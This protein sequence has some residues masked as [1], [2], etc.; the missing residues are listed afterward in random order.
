MH[1]CQFLDLERGLETSCV[2]IA[3]PHH[4]QRLAGI[5]LGRQLAHRVVL[6]QHLQDTSLHDNTS[7]EPSFL[8]GMEKS[9]NKLYEIRK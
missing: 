9:C 3:A 6:L 4:Q 2:A 5:E 1:V 8:G 7:T